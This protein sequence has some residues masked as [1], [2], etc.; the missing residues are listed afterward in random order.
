MLSNKELLNKFS[1]NSNNF[2]TIKDN[3]LYVVRSGSKAYNCHTESSDDDYKGFFVNTYNSYIG[4]FDKIEQFELKD[5]DAVIYE[6]SK[7]FKLAIV[8]N[9]NII[10]VLFVDPSDVLYINPI[11]EEI[12]NNRSLFLSKKIFHSMSGYAYSQMARLENHRKWI[13][14]PPTCAPIRSDFSLPERPLINK[15]AYNALKS[16]ISKQMLELSFNFLEDLTDE[17]REGIKGTINEYL[18]KFQIKNS[19]LEKNIC[20]RLGF[21]D[22]II[23]YVLKEREYESACTK[24]KQFLEWQVNRNKKRAADEARLGYDSKFAYHIIRLYRMCS[25]ILE[26]G[27]VIVKRPDRQDFMDI[28]NGLWSY[29]KLQE[30]SSNL[31]KKCKDLYDNC[32][33][34]PYSPD[35][36][37]INNLLIATINKT[38]K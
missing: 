31:Y 24:Y 10:E 35:K 32:K 29:E 23:E 38:F 22:N 17:Q 12:L 28:R 1:I 16:I 37:A 6:I 34:I 9:P 13:R 3:V 2:K 15:E 11:A 18:A 4:I 20:T 8:S 7:F 21:D 36:V 5:P 33:A 19:D 30:E 25:E 26:T 14:N 27:K